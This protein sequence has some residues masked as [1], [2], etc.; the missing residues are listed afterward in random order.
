VEGFGL[1]AVG[2]AGPLLGPLIGHGPKGVRPLQLH[3]LVKEGGDGLDHA[4][5]SVLG[6]EFHLLVQGGNLSL[7]G[8]RRY[9]SLMRSGYP[10]GNRR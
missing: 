7:V 5:E 4:V 9:D 6:Q 1:E 8:H 10:P 2:D 3:D